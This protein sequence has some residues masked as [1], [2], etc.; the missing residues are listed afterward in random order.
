MRLENVTLFSSV[1][2]AASQAAIQQ[3]FSESQW[4]LTI[5]GV[6]AGVAG[7]LK[8]QVSNDPAMLN[9]PSSIAS[10]SWVDLPN[11]TVTLAGANALLSDSNV[12]Y[13]WLK[14][15]WTPTGG[16]SGTFS[17]TFNSKGI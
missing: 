1:D 12:G 16:S 8:A 2:S 3:V 7:V 17:G 10:S 6:A 11:I 5:V 15:V 13:R 4:C 9:N 14:F